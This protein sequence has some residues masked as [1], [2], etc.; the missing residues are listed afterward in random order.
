[1]RR[2]ESQK[3]T[4]LEIVVIYRENSDKVRCFWPE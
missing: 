2:S 4:A 1:M 3:Y